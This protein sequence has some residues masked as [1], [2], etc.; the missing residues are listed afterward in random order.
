MAVHP[1]GIPASWCCIDHLSPGCPLTPHRLQV[2]TAQSIKAAQAQ[3]QTQLGAAAAAG[4]MGASVALAAGFPGGAA[5][6]PS[7][8]RG[9]CLL[10]CCRLLLLLGDAAGAATPVLPCCARAAWLGASSVGMAASKLER[11]SRG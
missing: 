10:S 6:Q 2:V 11:H 4:D 9:C 3:T 8:V 5:A 7:L 1:S